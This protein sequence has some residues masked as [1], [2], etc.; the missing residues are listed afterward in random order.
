MISVRGE[1]DFIITRQAQ[2]YT[3]MAAYR[4]Q[5]NWL[6]VPFGD[7]VFSLLQ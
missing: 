5:E 3:G 2:G 6:N 7:D 4:P 1:I